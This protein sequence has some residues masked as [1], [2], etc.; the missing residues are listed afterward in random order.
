M[1]KCCVPECAAT[2]SKIFHAF[3]ANKDVRSQWVENTKTFHLTE[4]DF[5]SYAKVCAYHFRE[6]DFEINCR[7]QRGLKKNIVPTLRLPGY[8][9]NLQKEHEQY[10]TY[11]F[12]SQCNIKTI[13]I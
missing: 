9:V 2:G 13:Q 8:E 10:N 5:K 6:T 1:V 11:T 12:V 3:P 7:G 4:K